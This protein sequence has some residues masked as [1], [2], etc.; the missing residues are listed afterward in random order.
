MNINREIFRT[1]DI[2]GVANVDLCDDVVEILGKSYG[3]F[4][5]ESS[6]TIA[7]GRDIR[8]SSTR[9][10]DAFVKGLLS[11]GKQIIDFGEIP[12]PLLYFVI[13]KHN[14]DGGIQ[15]TGSHNPKQYNG[16]KILVGKNTIYG[17]DI[18]KIGDI[19]DKLS[20]R[21]G[22][23]TLKI[24][25]TIDDYISYILQ[26]IPLGKKKIRI[27]FDAGNGTAGLVL[28]KLFD[29]TSV[30]FKILFEEP[31]GSFPN[32]L[33]DPTVPEF[34][35]DLIARV[36][37]SNAHIGIAFD[38]DADRIGAIDEAGRIIWGDKLLG[39]YS[40]DVI[41]QQPGA[42]IICE[43]KCSNGLIEY[44]Q[45]RGGTPLMWKTGHSLIKAKMKE[46]NA[47]LAGEMS[48]HMF[49]A[50]NYF[51]Y[52]DA[53]F[54]ALRLIGIL[55]NT[56]KSLSQ[57]ADEIPSYC[58]TPE[59]RIDCPDSKKFDVVKHVK[60]IFQKEYPIIDI[61]GVRVS[62]ADGWGLLRASNTQPVL[63]LRFEANTKDALDTI[64]KCFFEILKK[65]NFINT[66]QLRA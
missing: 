46:E 2:R 55:T 15:V 28:R 3:T 5:P 16:L 48:G 8:L 53:L 51:G 65:Y 63:V 52:D 27:V 36:K 17:N 1:Y 25:E 11:T 49:F 33:A 47:P 29:R 18:Q 58:T 61:D 57:L 23:G 21:K 56:E 39:I 34:L 50:D 64:R 13:H 62:F 32:H 41:T 44:I 35:I 31:D 22:K 19:A 60:Q 6:K 4:L 37:E 20:F 40:N 12:T 26:K 43:V 14:L 54:A 7:I 30:E 59:I 10:K 45:Q 66:D 42:T 9:I 38:G 24:G